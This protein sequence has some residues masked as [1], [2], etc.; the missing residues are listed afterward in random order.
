M[1]K[2]ISAIVVVIAVFAGVFWY[3]NAKT[4]MVTNESI[5][6]ASS[7]MA[8]STNQNNATTSTTINTTAS[9]TVM[10]YKMSDIAMHKDSSSC[11]TAISGEVF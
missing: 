9:T 4:P 7:T 5:N 3:K 8:T 2:I 10:T 1:N 11:W 6:T